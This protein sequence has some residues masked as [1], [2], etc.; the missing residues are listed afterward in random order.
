MSTSD[1]K[2]L[3]DVGVGK[4]VEDFLY[5]SGYDVLPVRKINP[6]MSDSEIIGIMKFSVRVS[7]PESGKYNWFEDI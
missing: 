4:K 6:R 1:L 2:F 3:V 5:K 7:Y